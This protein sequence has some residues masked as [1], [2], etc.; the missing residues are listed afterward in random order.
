MGVTI[1]DEDKARRLARALASDIRLYHEEELRTGADLSGPMAEARELFESRVVPAL[2]PIFDVA[3]A[4][5]G[6]TRVP[7]PARVVATSPASAAPREAP[8]R[9]RPVLDTSPA[10]SSG[11]GVGGLLAIAIILAAVAGGLVTYLVLRG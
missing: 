1:D 7:P 11:L 6:L 3:F 8:P 10:S 5:M 4:E 2:H 9:A